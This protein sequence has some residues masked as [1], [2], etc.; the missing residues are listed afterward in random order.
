M[1]SKSYEQLD[2][3]TWLDMPRFITVVTIVYNMSIVVEFMIQVFIR[4]NDKRET[5]PLDMNCIVN[6]LNV[7]FARK[8]YSIPTD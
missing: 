7:S 6:A 2:I 3:Y 5:T 8:I 1:L 4:G